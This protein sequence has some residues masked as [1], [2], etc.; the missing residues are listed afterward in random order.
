MTKMIALEWNAMSMEQR[1][2]FTQRAALDKQRAQQEAAVYK[3]SGAE[4]TWIAAN[5]PPETMP[6]P[7]LVPVSIVSGAAGVL[8]EAG[9]VHAGMQPVA[10]EQH[11]IVIPLPI[12]K[13][14]T[15]PMQAISFQTTPYYHIWTYNPGFYSLRCRLSPSK[16][17]SRRTNTLA[18][19]R[20]QLRPLW[21][22]P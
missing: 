22:H 14:L 1:S 12:V 7:R 21:V 20:S 13:A 15:P 16:P 5:L 6:P 19:N 11:R 3:S 9:M 18:T 10:S 17:R 4:A 2:P 8:A